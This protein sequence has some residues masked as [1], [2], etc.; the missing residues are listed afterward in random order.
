M[1]LQQQGNQKLLPA[2][3]PACFNIQR[4]RLGAQARRKT[5]LMQIDANPDHRRRSQTGF[6]NRLD[7]NSANFSLAN[8]QIIGPAKIGVERGHF[9]NCEM[10]SEPGN[11][12]QPDQVRGIEIWPQQHAEIKPLPGLRMPLVIAAPTPCG[13]FIC[14]I[15]T[16]VRR[17]FAG[18]LERVGVG[19]ID[20]AEVMKTLGEWCACECSVNPER[21]Q[22][23]G[24]GKRGITHNQ[25]SYSFSDFPL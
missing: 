25:H 6:C 9:A 5:P 24:I 10:S 23:A 4:S 19:R 20:G 17:A 21:V 18:L 16:A 3:D 22:V 15:E 14:D 8:Q 13:L 11:Q 1:K 12:R 7:K 2:D